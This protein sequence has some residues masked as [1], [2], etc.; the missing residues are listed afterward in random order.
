MNDGDCFSS[1]IIKFKKNQRNVTI[2]D[3]KPL[4]QNDKIQTY[5]IARKSQTKTDLNNV[6]F[7]KYLNLVILINSFREKATM[8]RDTQ[9]NHMQISRRKVVGSVTELG[10]REGSSKQ[11]HLFGGRI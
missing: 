2:A 8:H 7:F 10:V 1:K 4:L 11:A 5:Q 6:F 9:N 3:T